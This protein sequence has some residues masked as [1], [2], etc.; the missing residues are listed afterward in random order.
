MRLITQAA[1]TALAR[2]SPDRLSIT[3][4]LC[5]VE[6]D[7]AAERAIPAMLRQLSPT[8][9]AQA[10]LSPRERRRLAEMIGT[11]TDNPTPSDHQSR[12][13]GLNIRRRR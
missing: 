10:R 12:P 8:V 4:T 7:E 13:V 9:L 1:L 11:T 5:L 2:R 3:A 6:T